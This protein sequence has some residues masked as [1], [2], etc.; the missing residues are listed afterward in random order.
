MSARPEPLPVSPEVVDADS[1]FPGL[2][3]FREEDRIY[4]SGRGREQRELVRR[5]ERHRLTVLFGRSGLGKTSLLQ[6]GVFPLLR[7]LDFVP[8]RVRIDYGETAPEPAAQIHAQLQAVIA[9]RKIDGGPPRNG[10]TLWA[11]F[12]R[13]E[14]WSERNHVLTPVLVLDQFEEV[15]TLGRG[16]PGVAPFL[17]ELGDLVENRIPAALR[18]VGA[19]LSGVDG[20]DGPGEDAEIDYDREDFRVVLSLREDF[21]PHLEELRPRMP[22]LAANRLRLTPLTREQAREAILKPAG[23]L[24]TPEVADA[25]LGFVSGA[26]RR[27]SPAGAVGPVGTA[28]AGASG[29]SGGAGESGE[30]GGIEPALLALVCHELNRRRRAAGQPAFTTALL[31]GVREQILQDFYRRSVKDL[32]PRVARFIEECLLTDSGFRRAESFDDALRQPGV[33]EQALERLI[34]RRLL[35]REERLGIPHVELIH[36]VMTGVVRESRDR[37][38]ADE[39]RRSLVRR[40]IAAALVLA[41]LF[42]GGLYELLRVRRH[43]ARADKLAQLVVFD[44]A[45]LLEQIEDQDVRDRIVDE[46]GQYLASWE[47]ADGSPEQIRKEAGAHLSIANH[48]FVRGRSAEARKELETAARLMERLTAVKPA[49]ETERQTLFGTHLQLGQLHGQFGRWPEAEKA[50]RDALALAEPQADLTHPSGWWWEDARIR[51]HA[52]LGDLFRARDDF[53]QALTQYQQALSLREQLARAAPDAA[54]WSYV[55]AGD[56]RRLGYAQI[57]SGDMAA[58]QKSF[59]EAITILRNLIAIQPHN[60]RLRFEVAGCQN[61]LGDALN[62]RGSHAEALVAYGDALAVYER[63]AAE[64]ARP[65][66]SIRAYLAYGHRQVATALSGLG[67]RGE[68][69]GSFERAL[70]I[71]QELATEEPQNP[72][73][74]IERQDILLRLAG[75]RWAAG[76]AE[77]ALAAQDEALAILEP[78][79]AADPEGL[80]LQDKLAA[81]REA[82]VKLLLDLGRTAPAVVQARAALAIREKLAVRED[83]VNPL[84]QGFLLNGIRWQLALALDQAGEPAEADALAQTALAEA[85]RMNDAPGRHMAAELLLVGALSAQAQVHLRQERA[86]PALALLDEAMGVLQRLTPDL[87]RR[88]ETRGLVGETQL[89]RGEAL[90]ALGRTAE[91]RQAWE[92]SLA[93]ADELSAAFESLQTFDLQA[94]SGLHLGRTEEA[95]PA[96]RRLLAVGWDRDG[97]QDLARRHGFTP[98]PADR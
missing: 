50:V 83:M 43:L 56:L 44:L 38:R 24:V 9:E 69:G 90:A 73:W 5:I 36:D 25:I 53:P 89:L 55:R 4:F 77:E 46:A 8:V 17:E 61:D 74:R 67:R 29:A 42:G 72:T 27:L 16:K 52:T 78:L 94:R 86:E 51:C 71:L 95:G 65:D 97:F 13:A 48:L 91:A 33:S 84:S 96:V 87:Q 66:T 32:G 18:E 28:P 54:D 76:E 93:I 81:A 11:Y 64:I 49:N 85:R 41:L 35:R 19:V 45:P 22:S 39:R 68:A 63:S 7:E 20:V 60:S 92:Q 57:A 14:W 70:E 31:A 37:R 80:F 82:R 21:L 26:E 30:A 47:G 34:D 23:A 1:P 40:L 15:F 88:R 3:A 58:G 98:D 79:A 2:A 12:H 10:E 62:M 59:E 6:A 75:N